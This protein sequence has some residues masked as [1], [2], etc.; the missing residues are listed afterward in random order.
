MGDMLGAGYMTDVEVLNNPAE[1]NCGL[2]A[3]LACASIRRP[4]ALLANAVI[5]D[6]DSA[7][8]LWCGSLRRPG[9]SFLRAPCSGHF[10]TACSLA[11]WTRDGACSCSVLRAARL[12]A[13]LVFSRRP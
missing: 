3:V 12:N 1:T 13:S 10:S 6:P 4:W 8:A 2:V 11:A 5:R 9:R 7:Q